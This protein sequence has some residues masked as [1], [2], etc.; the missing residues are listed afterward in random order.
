MGEM[1]FEIMD[2]ACSNAYSE[3]MTTHSGFQLIDIP[4]NSVYRQ[5]GVGKSSSLIIRYNL[6]LNKYQENHY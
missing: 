3:R 2:S 1:N 6:K 4:S 5:L